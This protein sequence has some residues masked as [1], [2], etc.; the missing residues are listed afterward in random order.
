MVNYYKKLVDKTG[1]IYSLDMVRYN[2]ELDIDNFDDYINEFNLEYGVDCK[3]YLNKKTVGYKYMYN[4]TISTPSSSCSFVIGLCLNCLSENDRKGFIEF[5][6]NKCMSFDT[7]FD[8]FKKLQ[9][10]C[11]SI[12]L[13]RYDCAIDLPL[14]RSR[15]K[16][17]RD[18]H[19]NYEYEIVDTGGADCCRSVTEYQGRRN[20]NKFCKLYDKTAESHL[21]YDVTRIE[22]TF[23]RDEVQFNCL[24][25]FVVYD[26][27]CFPEVDF[28]SF[29]DNDLVLVDLLR[30]SP[31]MGYYIKNL[32]YRKRR[33]ILPLVGD[34]YLNLNY[35]LILKVRELALCF[36]I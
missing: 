5:N 6:P 25:R 31:D 7:F 4:L 1:Y 20:N 8:F 30:N 17:V 28:Y 35:V 11:S 26:N 13:I 3:F 21:D 27:N 12:T 9:S 10:C 23:D 33:K 34:Y 18:F 22:F 29:S 19:C 2:F 24:P 36:E 32:S 15:V 16:M 14:K